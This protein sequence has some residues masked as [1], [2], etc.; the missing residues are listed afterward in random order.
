MAQPDV[1][2]RHPFACVRDSRD[3]RC[4]CFL[5]SGSDRLDSSEALRF[6]VYMTVAQALIGG[7]LL[8]VARWITKHRRRNFTTENEKDLA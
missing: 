8:F 4:A 7:I 2:D 5:G 1:F 6:G 3:N